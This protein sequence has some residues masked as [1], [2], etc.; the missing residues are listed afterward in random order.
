MKNRPVDLSRLRGKLPEG[1]ICPGRTGLPTAEK[2]EKR[3]LNM[4]AMKIPDWL[5][6]VKER[7]KSDTI[8][9]KVEKVNPEKRLPLKDSISFKRSTDYEQYLL[10]C[11]DEQGLNFEIYDRIKVLYL[12]AKDVAGLQRVWKRLSELGMNE[13]Q[14]WLE[15]ADCFRQ[16]DRL[17]LAM[18]FLEKNVSAYP[19]DPHA[20]YAMGMYYKLTRNYELALHWLKKWTLLDIAN[21]EAHFQLGSVYRRVNS[22]DLAKKSLLECLRISPGH[23]MAKSLLEKIR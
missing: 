21:S 16:L 13:S 6:P 19:K 15:K 12:S 1:L 9:D 18:E 3:S 22:L 8:G 10:A 17:D 20:N 5:K 2:S 11:I 14:I 23:I 7:K 4:T